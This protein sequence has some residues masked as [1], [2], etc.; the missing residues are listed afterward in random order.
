MA[1]TDSSPI[2]L[3]AAAPMIKPRD[4]AKRLPDVIAGGLDAILAT[5]GAIEDFR[6]TME[7]VAKWLE[8][9]RAGTHKIRIARSVADIRAAKA[10]GEVAIVLHFQ[11]S[12][13]I[14]DE[15]DFLNVF[16]ACGL[17]VMQLTYNSR[18]RIG[19]GCFESSDVGLSKFGRK[20]IRRM[21]SLS[22][23]VDLAHAGARTALEATEV[24]TRPLII[25]HAN[26]RALLESP[27]NV[28]DDL[29]RAVATSGG[30]I[31]VCAA[32][33]FLSRHGP[34]TL[35]M[36]IDHAA[37]IADL[38]G[39]QHVGLGFDFAEE[40]ADDYIYYGYD[41]RYIPMPP[42]TFPSRIAGHA[43]A[44]NVET[45]LRGRGFGEIE[46]RGILGENFLR[47]FGEIWGR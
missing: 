7:V 12:D 13:A 5:A 2:L 24:A 11:G 6:T 10:A 1:T 31:G 42:W 37:Y 26:A 40:D 4:V 15:L 47:V 29:I 23:V 41:E 19:D 34:A 38:V 30:V 27:R 33:F 22:M 21:E 17:R 39:P 36:L 28:G 9:E 18:N 35:D 43:D 46:I 8:I 16:Q 44:G 3:D 14:E 25:S 32:P 20:V 45:S